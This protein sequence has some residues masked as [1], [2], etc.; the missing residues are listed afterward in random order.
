[1]RGEWVKGEYVSGEQPESAF[2]KASADETRNFELE[3]IKNI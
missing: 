2:A 3:N 1:V